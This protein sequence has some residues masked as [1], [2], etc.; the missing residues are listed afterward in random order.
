M[1]RRILYARLL[2]NVI[3]DVGLSDRLVELEALIS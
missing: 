2:G 3:R 1:R